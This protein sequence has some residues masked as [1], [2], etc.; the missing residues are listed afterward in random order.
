MI[1]VRNKFGA[2]QET[3]EKHIPN[4]KYENIVTAHLEATAECIPTKPTAKWE[5]LVSFGFMAYQPLKVS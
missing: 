2:L 4:D 1:T 3:F 5:S